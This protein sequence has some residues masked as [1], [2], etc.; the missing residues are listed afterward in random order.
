MLDS[1]GPDQFSCGGGPSVELRAV[2]RPFTSRLVCG[3]L[4]LFLLLL[5][6]FPC[7]V[8]FRPFPCDLPGRDVEADRDDHSVG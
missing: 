7:L 8:G 6:P 4:I 5:P 3:Y 2:R 1:N